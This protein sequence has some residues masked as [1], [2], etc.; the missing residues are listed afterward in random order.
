MKEY[1]PLFHKVTGSAIFPYFMAV[2]CQ[3]LSL[4]KSSCI[5]FVFLFSEEIAFYNGNL[6]EKQ[7][8]HKTFRKLVSVFYLLKHFKWNLILS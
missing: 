1:K 4:T 7:T 3:R 5:I 8:I 6:R 2:F